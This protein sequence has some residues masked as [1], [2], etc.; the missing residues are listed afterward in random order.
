MHL[1]NSNRQALTYKDPLKGEAS[2]HLSRQWTWTF[3]VHI[4]MLFMLALRHV[5]LFQLLARLLI[6]WV[7]ILKYKDL[8]NLLCVGLEPVDVT[9]HHHAYLFFL[10]WLPHSFTSTEKQFV[11][12]ED[13]IR[14]QTGLGSVMVLDYANFLLGSD[15]NFGGNSE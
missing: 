14:L 9:G 11:E 8:L 1:S 15:A 3:I 10:D 7:T 13:I 2:L 4:F 12:K 6:H 5:S